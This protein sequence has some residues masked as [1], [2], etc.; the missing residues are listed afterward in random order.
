MKNP[1]TSMQNKVEKLVVSGVLALPNGVKRGLA[2]MLSERPHQRLDADVRFLLA[3]AEHRPSLA[4]A[5]VNKSRQLYAQ[6]I[7]L[8]DMP[9]QRLEHV[10]DH[11]VALMG[12]RIKLREYRPRHTGVLTHAVFF[13]HGGGFTIGDVESYDRLCR[14]IAHRLDCPVF[15]LDYRLAPEH[16]YPVAIDDAIAAWKWLQREALELG[17]D[18]DKITVMGDSA[19]ATI[20]AVLAQQVENKPM[21]QCLI[22]PST[23][24]SRVF[25]SAEE[26]GEGYGLT[27]EVM[28]W[29]R[30]QY[31]PADA[32][33]HDPR[34][35]PLLAED[36]SGLPNTLM[37][38]ATDPLRDE[39]LAYGHRLEEAGV[40][41]K[42]LHYPKLVH[43]FVSM[44]GMVP[45]A[46]R[47]LED[48]CDAL[49][50]L[51]K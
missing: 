19:G 30:Q 7:N 25:P 17:I 46:R 37:I 20:S 40:A 11:Q 27:T 29:F 4:Q 39:G 23:D 3:T 10:R 50:P 22:Y 21:A 24:Q 28:A 41:V 33:V 12:G 5:D 36:L 14:W 51:M 38:T 47:A 16:Q 48:I 6:M 18:P 44:G 31:L 26:F 15:S 9:Y 49:I 43:G 45:A 32:D 35:S 2:A 8:L 42:Y 13:S 34:I 1:L